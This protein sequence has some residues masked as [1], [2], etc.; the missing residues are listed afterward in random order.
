MSKNHFWR[1]CALF[2]MLLPV[3]ACSSGTY[4]VYH[5]EN[6]DFASIQSVAVLPFSNLTRDNMAAER[7]RDVVMTMLLATGGIYVIPPGE[8]ARG[9]ATAGISNPT[10]PSD[11]DIKKLA[12]ALKADA[13]ISGVLREYGD[14]RQ[15][16]TAGNIIS[17]SLQLKEA[18]AGKVVWSASSTRG[19]IGMKER[20]I[21]GGGEPMNNITEKAVNEII[22]KLFK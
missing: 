17:F 19:G 6:M 8:V 10:N 9:I 16:Q 1:R 2:I 18:Q 12:V 3:L 11:G 7:V 22:N 21:G 4:D 5:S 14:V 15:M 13:I 20:L